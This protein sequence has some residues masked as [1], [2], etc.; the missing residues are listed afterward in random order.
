MG[1]YK[2]PYRLPSPRRKRHLCLVLVSLGDAICSLQPACAL[3]LSTNGNTTTGCAWVTKNS[4]YAWPCTWPYVHDWNAGNMLCKRWVLGNQSQG[5]VAVK[6]LLCCVCL[7]RQNLWVVWLKFPSIYPCFVQTSRSIHELV[8][9]IVKFPYHF[10]W[11]FLVWH[12]PVTLIIIKPI[13]VAQNE[14]SFNDVL[15]C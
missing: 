4:V 13:V 2:I 8:A 6:A 11:P 14:W 15:W 5:L 1:V 7:V 9:P 10:E 12:K 3:I